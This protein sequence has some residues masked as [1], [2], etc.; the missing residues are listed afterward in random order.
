MNLF[1]VRPT[2]EAC[3]SPLGLLPPPLQEGFQ[4]RCFIGLVSPTRSFYKWLRPVLASC[5]QL[6]LHTDT[7]CTYTFREFRKAA[8]EVW[9]GL[10]LKREGENCVVYRRKPRGEAESFRLMVVCLQLV[11][12]EVKRLFGIAFKVALVSTTTASLKGTWVQASPE[13][14]MYRKFNGP[15]G[16]NTREYHLYSPLQRIT[17]ISSK[18]SVFFTEPI[19]FFTMSGGGE[20][21]P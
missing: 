16:I 18:S 19:L 17:K 5:V 1:I 3:F 8:C 7:E 13:G 11:L 4:T 12:I 21:I 9:P 6:S 20:M 2:S 10:L 15:W 14:D